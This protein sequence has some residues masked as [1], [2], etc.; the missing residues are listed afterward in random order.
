MCAPCANA[1]PLA[2]AC[3]KCGAPAGMPCQRHSAALNAEHHV[4]SRRAA[5]PPAA[6]PAAASPGRRPACAGCA[7]LLAEALE[8]SRRAKALDADVNR[9]VSASRGR[10]ATPAAAILTQ[11]DQDL[12]AWE[13]RSRQ[14]LQQGCFA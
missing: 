8:L 6:R 13:A 14:H 3:P 9:A 7:G 12:A 5:F 2:V 10:C 11:Y 4:R 1:D